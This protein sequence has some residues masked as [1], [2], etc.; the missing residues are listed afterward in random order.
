MPVFTIAKSSDSKGNGIYSYIILAI[1]S[2]FI[3]YL[4]YKFF[5]ATS[6]TFLV[7]GLSVA[8]IVTSFVVFLLIPM[9]VSRET[10]KELPTRVTG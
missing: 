1:G 5:T 9:F 3:A 10:T 7:L 4:L 6:V 8:F 2:L